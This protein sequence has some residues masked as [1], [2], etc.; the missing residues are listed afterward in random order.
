VF[1]VAGLL[2]TGWLFAPPIT[3][4]QQGVALR[5]RWTTGE[6]LHYRSTQQT[7]TV[8]SGL[9]GGLGD[10]NLDQTLTQVLRIEVTAVAADGT[11]TLQESIESVKMESTTPAG[12]ITYDTAAADTSANQP[13][14]VTGIFSA[15]IGEP[16]TIVMA[17]T[18]VVQK[19]EG[20]SRIFEKMSKYAPE[21]PAGAAMWKTM[22][23]IFNDDSMRT[24]LSPGLTMLPDHPVGPGETWNSKT[25]MQNPIVGGVTTTVAATLTS[26]EGATDQMAKITT[27]LTI[28]RDPTGA[29]AI[30]PP[31]FE[32]QMGDNSGDGEVVFDVTRG[33]LERSISRTSMPM[34]M[35]GRG[36]DGTPLSM[37]TT[38]KN[39][40]TVERIQE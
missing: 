17:P 39:T 29:T 6:T 20:F 36:P 4:L 40:V 13:S 33:R 38:V 21:G 16:F 19:A 14:P 27:Q 22:K 32:M 8:V 34:S 9:P 2:F 12:K 31:G 25:T 18:G 11:T 10:T 7:S 28:E 37:K 1:T 30:V 23:G 35:S 3:A 24:M 26:V 15:M 5:Y